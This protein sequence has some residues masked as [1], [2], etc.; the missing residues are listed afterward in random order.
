VVGQHV[1]LRHVERRTV[2]PEERRQFHRGRRGTGALAPVDEHHPILGKAQVRDA[3]IAMDQRLLVGA[4]LVSERRRILEDRGDRLGDVSRQVVER[5]EAAEVIAISDTARENGRLAY[6]SA[7][8]SRLGRPSGLDRGSG[9]GEASL[10]SPAMKKLLLLVI[11]A[12]LAAVAAKKV[13]AA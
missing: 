9:G 8:A 13:R 1:V 2:E 12:A 3:D 5:R 10:G 6:E 7:R 11:L 4:Q